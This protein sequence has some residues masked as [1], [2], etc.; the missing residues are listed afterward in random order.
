MTDRKR[1]Q[2]KQINPDE[3]AKLVRRNRPHAI[4]SEAIVLGSCLIDATKIGDVM[5]VLR[6]PTDFYKPAHRPIYET[7]AELYDQNQL[8]DDSEA[9]D[10]TAVKRRLEDRGLL[11]AVGGMEYII[12]LAEAVASSAGAYYHAQVVRD[13]AKARDLADACGRVLH[14]LYDEDQSLPETLDD[15]EREIMSIGDGGSVSGPVDMATMLQQA[16]DNAQH[17]REHGVQANAMSTGFADLD[18]KLDGGVRPEFVIVAA[19]P[20]MGKSAMCLNLAQRFAVDQ[21]RPVMFFSLEMAAGEIGLRLMSAASNVPMQKIR[22]GQIGEGE[23]AKLRQAVETQEHAPLYIE[24]RASASILQLRAQA[25]RYARRMA[26]QAIFVDYIQLMHAPGQEN[27]QMEVSTISRGLKSL[28]RELGIPVI[29][30]SQLSRKSEDRA[31]KRP[32]L[33]DLRESGSLEQDAD[34]VM[35][36]HRED[37][38]RPQHERLDYAADVIVAKQRNGPT[39]TV[40]LH[41]VGETNRFDN[42]ADDGQDQLVA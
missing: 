37:Y 4:D 10:E 34:T 13:K 19:R 26:L 29:A 21:G 35:M 33:S 18:A 9:V 36:L 5:Q 6:G 14:N 2:P 27:R 1:K 42:R 16:Y 22:R 7:L 25:R 3:L 41:F 32:T 31:D 30:M 20:S 28:Q 17:A 11:D 15:A 38:Y 8:P 12:D 40:K 23:C 24:E 39:G